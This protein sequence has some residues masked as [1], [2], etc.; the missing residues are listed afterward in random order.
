MEASS[1]GL[2]QRRMEAVGLAAA[3]FTNLTQDHLD[4]HGDMETYF[5]AKLRLFTELLPEDGVAVVNLDDDYGPRVAEACAERDVEV[6][7][8]AQYAEG[9]AIKI[10]GR[11]LDETGQDV[12][13][14]LAGSGRCRPGWAS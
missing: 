1:H 7:G 2:D 4:Y 10:T 3:G 13:L 9:A 6:M 11:R 14:S 5:A 12:L 8:V